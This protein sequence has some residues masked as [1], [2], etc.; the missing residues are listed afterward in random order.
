M[1][2]LFFLAATAV[3]CQGFVGSKIIRERLIIIKNL[4]V[5]LE[6]ES[7]KG[8]V[9]RRFIDIHRVRDIVIN[10]VR[11]KRDYIIDSI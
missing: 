11:I 9:K 3:F 4:G 6:T 2:L 10:E 7:L 8:G 5:Q 1:L